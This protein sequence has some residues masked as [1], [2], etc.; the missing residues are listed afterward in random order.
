MAGKKRV[1]H[2]SKQIV[3]KLQQAAGATDELEL[4]GK[5]R[6]GELGVI[7][8]GAEFDS[9]AGAAA[10]CAVFPARAVGYRRL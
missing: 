10:F 2:K 4:P 1:H 3:G 6:G 8:A 7:D 9:A 5:T